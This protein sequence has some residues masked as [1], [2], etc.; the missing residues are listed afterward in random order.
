M[1]CPLMSYA[2]N[3]VECVRQECAIWD[4]REDCCGFLSVGQRVENSLERIT[5]T[6]NEIKVKF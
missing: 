3:Q 2:A 5:S 6:M 4:K 1:I